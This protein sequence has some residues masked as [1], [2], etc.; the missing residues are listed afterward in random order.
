M[1]EMTVTVVGNVGNDP[2]LKTL[3]SGVKVATFSVANTPRRFDRA[4]ATWVDGDTSWIHVA[5]WRGLAENVKASISKGQ[6]V[7]VYGRFKARLYT[8]AA[9]QTRVVHELEAYSVG[10]DLNLGTSEFTRR[11][12]PV[13]AVERDAAGNPR[14][15]GVFDEDGRAV[16]TGSGEV[17]D[18]GLPDEDVDPF[19]TSLDLGSAGG[20]LVPGLADAA[21]PE[22][23]A[24]T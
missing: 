21:L 6:R 13:A 23:A 9:E 14:H 15:P 19:A 8:N 2:E 10:H 12:A 5:A 11:T 20:P 4:K 3:D 1:N 16:D 17:Y 7:V 22:F 24:V 18:H